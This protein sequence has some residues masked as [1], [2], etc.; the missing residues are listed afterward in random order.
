MVKVKK[1]GIILEPTKREFECEAV[2]NPATIREGDHVHIYYR[3]V[4]WGNYSSIGYAKLD[5]PLDVI[6]RAKKPLMKPKYKY[7]KQGMEDPRIVKI[8]DTYYMTYVAYDGK[9][10]ITAYATSKDLRKFKR[11]GVITPRMSYNKA[12]R[13]MENSKLKEKYFWFESYYKDTIAEDILLRDKDVFFFPKKIGGKFALFQRIIP[14]IQLVF[15]NNF[16]NLDNGFWDSYLRNL[17]KYVVIEPKYGFESRNI[18]GGCPPVETDRGWIVIY[19][20]VEDS[21]Q[22]KVYHAAAA[23]LDKR[24]P[25]K[26]KGH[27]KVPLFSPEKKWECRGIVNHVVFPTGTAIF[28]NKLYIYYGAADK[29]IAVASVNINRLVKDMLKN[30]RRKGSRCYHRYK[31]KKNV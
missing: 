29:K 7:E 13:L 28:G 21:N 12:A 5:G 26:V 20:A 19:H 8:G 27:L 10:A 25:M 15:F 18:G 16:H 9:D 4:K 17:S 22:G 23:L 24:N 3:A 30:G 14:D 1:H 31:S 11:K 6:E 2:L